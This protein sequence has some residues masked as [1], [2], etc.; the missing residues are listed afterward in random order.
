MDRG[1]EQL[2]AREAH[3]L[4]VIGSSPV[5]AT[6]KAVSSDSRR[7]FLFLGLI[8]FLGSVSANASAKLF[9]PFP[10]GKRS[11]KTRGFFH[12]ILIR[13]SGFRKQTLSNSRLTLRRRRARGAQRNGT[14]RRSARVQAALR[15][16]FFAKFLQIL[17]AFSPGLRYNPS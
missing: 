5:P 16:L 10:F 11:R 9:Q 6:L 7:L 13:R 8:L 4:E 17:L 12:W 15:K 2:V 1:V 3:N 14:I